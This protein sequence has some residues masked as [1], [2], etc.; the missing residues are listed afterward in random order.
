M[1]LENEKGIVSYF[2]SRRGLY[3]LI[4]PLGKETPRPIRNRA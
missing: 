1:K 2:E 4:Q 3:R